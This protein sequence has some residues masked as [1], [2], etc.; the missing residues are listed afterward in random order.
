MHILTSLNSN[1]HASTT[2]KATEIPKTN[3][4]Y[5]RLCFQS[6]PLHLEARAHAHGYSH[7]ITA[8][9]EP[10]RKSPLSIVLRVF[11]IPYFQQYRE[12]AERAI[13]FSSFLSVIVSIHGVECFWNSYFMLSHIHSQAFSLAASVLVNCRCHY[14]DWI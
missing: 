4:W 11:S 3:N 6:A 5:S 12:L 14:P 13:S 9:D 10:R 7:G 2:K 1:M 8:F